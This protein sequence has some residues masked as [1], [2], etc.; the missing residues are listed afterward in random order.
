MQTGGNC[1]PG[2]AAVFPLRYCSE[3]KPGHGIGLRF[4]FAEKG[5]LDARYMGALFHELTHLFH[6]ASIDGRGGYAFPSELASGNLIYEIEALCFQNLVSSV[7]NKEPLTPDYRAL[8][9]L[10]YIARTE[11]LLYSERIDDSKD[12]K[13]FVEQRIRQVYPRGGFIRTPL[14]ASVM[15]SGTN[16]GMFWEYPSAY[17]Q[18]IKKAVKI[19]ESPDSGIR[20]ES[21]AAGNEISW[22]DPPEAA[23]Q[24]SAESPEDLN[25]I[26]SPVEFS[27]RMGKPEDVFREMTE[28]GIRFTAD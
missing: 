12:L 4:P 3:T 16:S 26:F 15:I 20:P 27:L 11:K 18:G 1:P 6:F 23:F 24:F 5:M 10:I 7:W 28:A 21:W 9:D 17:L 19:A 8:K 13:D 22:T 2:S 14:G 25:E